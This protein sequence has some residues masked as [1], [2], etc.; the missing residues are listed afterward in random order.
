MSMAGPARQPQSGSD[1]EIVALRAQVAQLEATIEGL[2]RELLLDK[3]RLHDAQHGHVAQLE[4]TIEG[5]R[6]ELLLDKRR[7]HDAQ[8]GHVA[9][10]QGRAYRLCLAYYR[11]YGNPLVGP[12]LRRLRGLAGRALR[13]IRGRG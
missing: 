8:H 13:A 3:R 1:A 2:R 10:L 6:R 9:V 7:L 11:L 4:A 12:P 5:L